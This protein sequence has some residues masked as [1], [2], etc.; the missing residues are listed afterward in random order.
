MSCLGAS[1]LFIFFFLNL[2]LVILPI[3]AD[4]NSTLDRALG[5]NC[6]GSGLCP[7]NYLAA[8]YIGFMLNI[9]HGLAKCNP[10]SSFNCGPLNDT[11]FYQ[12]GANIICLPQ[13]KS[14]LG[15][16]CAF[17]QGNVRGPGTLGFQVK[18]KLQ[19]LSAHGCQV[20]GSVPLANSNDPAEAGIL[21]VNYISGAACPGLCP[22]TH[23]WAPHELVD[24]Y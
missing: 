4:S 1:S 12:A 18:Q 7:S 6:R 15:G 11:D 20:C 21:T 3:N 8:D 24:T 22:P 23:F 17:T 5:I 2:I 10:K 16:I 14:F 9:A 13:G 19:Q